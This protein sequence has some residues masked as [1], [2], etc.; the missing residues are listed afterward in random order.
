MKRSICIFLI[1]AILCLCTGCEK[2]TQETVFAM[3]TVMDLQVWGREG[4]QAM[5][6]IR[7]ILT[8]QERLWSPADPDSMLHTPGWEHPLLTQAQ[9]LSQRTGGAFDPQLGQVVACWGFYTKDYCVPD[10]A[11]LEQA[12]TQKRWDLGAAV[13]GYT[14]D[15]CVAALDKLDVDR[16]ILNL[17]GNVQTYGEKPDGSA[18]QIGI[19][20]PDGGSTAATVSV[21]GTMA[22]VTSGDYQRYFEQDGVRYH[23][24]IDPATGMPASSGL[25]S[26]TVICREGVTADALSTALFVM[27]LEKAAAHWQQYGDFEAV[28]I[29]DTG[30]IYAT[31]GA[32]V[33]G[34]E[35][36]V[37]YRENETLDRGAGGGAGPVP[38]A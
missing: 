22:V 21:T 38:G 23:H 8:E 11:Q 27:G 15:L 19:Q 17:G 2:K 14:G 34:C 36:E 13:K 1:L 35:Y 4:E 3:D 26:V 20:N 32:V 7:L 18:W 16:A 37:I 28:F 30:K 12:M 31:Q 5:A 9:A 24:I 10:Q 33:S 25:R 6:A 29:T